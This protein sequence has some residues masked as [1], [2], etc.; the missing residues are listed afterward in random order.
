MLYFCGKS[1]GCSRARQLNSFSRSW[2][3]AGAG[4]GG[5]WQ[6]RK[7]WMTDPPVHAGTLAGIVGTGKRR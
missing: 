5:Y 3:L 2:R 1:L 4:V 6:A 7:P